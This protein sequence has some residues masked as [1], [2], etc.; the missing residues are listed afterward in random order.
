M[1][2]YHSNRKVMDREFGTRKQTVVGIYL[3]LHVEEWWKSI[4]L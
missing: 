1:E 2:F 3:T 4:E